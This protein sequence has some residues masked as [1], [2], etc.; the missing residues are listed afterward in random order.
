MSKNSG[1]VSGGRNLQTSDNSFSWNNGRAR[2]K[3]IAI[4][5]LVQTFSETSDCIN[6]CDLG[7]TML[8][9]ID[10]CHVK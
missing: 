7:W 3:F 2:T 8:E 9:W 10:G 1:F 6:S 5:S 4:E